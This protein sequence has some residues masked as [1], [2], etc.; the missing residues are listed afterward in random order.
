MDDVV[1]FVCMCLC[2]RGLRNEEAQ[3]VFGACDQQEC[4]RETDR[5]WH[6]CD[7]CM[8]LC[9]KCVSLCYACMSVY[10]MC[11]PRS[12]TRLPRQ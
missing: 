1:V 5:V 11:M 2:V 7:V 10:C 12:G 6:T 3:A 9:R 8:S 4:D